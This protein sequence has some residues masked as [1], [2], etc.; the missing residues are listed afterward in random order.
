MVTKCYEAHVKKSVIEW[1]HPLKNIDR[2]QPWTSRN[3]IASA[4]TV[5][6]NCV[7][8]TTANAQSW[9]KPI[10]RLWESLSQ[11]TNRSVDLSRARRWSLSTRR[12]H[13]LGKLADLIL[14]VM[15]NGSCNS[16]FVN[17]FPYHTPFLCNILI[18]PSKWS[19][20]FTSSSLPPRP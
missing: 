17:C 11:R 20:W 12:P 8:S 6:V 13:P 18:L 4:V 2:T 15:T 5:E 16:L 10:D 3:K 19:S 7:F 9:A 1:V 14:C